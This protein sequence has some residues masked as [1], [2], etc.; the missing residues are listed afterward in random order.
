VL[1]SRYHTILSAQKSLQMKDDTIQQSVLF[2]ELVDKP[3]YVKFDQPDSSSDGGAL[4]LKAADD[5][6]D[7]TAALARC[8]KDKRRPDMIIHSYLDLVRQRI[9]GMACGYEDC[10]DAARL[11]NDPMHRLLLDRDPIEG[12]ELASQPTLCR[13]E[14]ALDVRSMDHMASVLAD[15]VVERHKKRLGGRVRK[16][17]IDMDPTD[18]PTY[19]QQQLSFYNSHYGNWCYLPVACF[20]TF[21]DEPDQYLF[22]YVLRPGDAH[23][24]YGAIAILQRIVKRLRKAFRRAAIHVRLDGGFAAPEV[25]DYLEEAKLKY[26]VAIANNSVLQGYAEPLMKKA[27]RD[28]RL[29]SETEHR[30]GE[31]QYMAGSW[32]TERR[33]IFKSEVVRHPGREPR[34]NPRFVVTN[35]NTSAQHIY[36]KIYCLRGCIENR[37]KELLYGLQIDRTSCTKFLSNQFRVLLCAA[38]YVLMQEIRL[39]ASRTSLANAQVTTLREKLFKQAVWLEKS[40]RRFVLHMPDSAPWRIDWCQIARQLGAVP[41]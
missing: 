38:A 17:T 18:D 29:S 41:I 12:L 24:S 14:N 31:C 33:V 22:A 21:N 13:F 10:N 16:I 4:L 1:E 15:R 11:V 19:G 40:K 25:F 28:S 37:I 27:R 3:L 23:A 2:E 32:D 30:Y 6:L 5:R 26:V 9:F 7:L 8:L 39:K 36:E 35:L 34:D 20:L